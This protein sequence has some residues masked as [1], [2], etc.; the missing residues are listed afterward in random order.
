MWKLDIKS[1]FA[2]VQSAEKPSA[3]TEFSSERL[4][5]ILVLFF[6]FFLFPSVGSSPVHLTGCKSSR[7]FTLGRNVLV[8]RPWKRQSEWEW[9]LIFGGLPPW[10][11]LCKLHI[12]KV[13]RAI[14]NEANY[15]RLAWPSEQKHNQ[16][17]CCSGTNSSQEKYVQHA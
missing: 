17:L 9:S 6:L 8:R 15:I 10:P 2:L 13:M 12:S 11:S 16:F 14:I 3:F 7:N 4:A 1:W 5:E